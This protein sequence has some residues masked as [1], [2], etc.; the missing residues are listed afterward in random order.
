MGGTHSELL[1]NGALARNI[2]KEVTATDA[3]LQLQTSTHGEPSAQIQDSPGVV[4]STNG[5]PLLHDGVE[6]THVEP[7]CERI[8]PGQPGSGQLGVA[9]AEQAR[10]LP[11]AWTWTWPLLY[12]QRGA[13]NQR[14]MDV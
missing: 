7:D 13:A 12:P 2:V 14:Q 5:L 10:P 11:R 4:P 8:S 3:S 1:L 6:P 9:G